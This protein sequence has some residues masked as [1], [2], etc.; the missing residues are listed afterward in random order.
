MF[1]SYCESINFCLH[2][3]APDK[4]LEQKI[5]QANPLMEAFGNSRTVINDNSSRFGKYIDMIFNNIGSVMGGMLDKN[6][7]IHF[8]S[9]IKLL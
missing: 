2:F 5:L 9:V 7:Q 3:Q 4:S 8:Y 1:T 6:K